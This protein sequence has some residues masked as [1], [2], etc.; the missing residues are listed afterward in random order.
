MKKL[1]EVTI[2]GMLT[3][4]G[5]YYFNKLMVLLWDPNFYNYFLAQIETN[6]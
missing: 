3:Y 5:Q 1:L 4:K 6:L 2:Q